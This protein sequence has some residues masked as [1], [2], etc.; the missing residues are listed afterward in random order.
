MLSSFDNTSM[1]NSDPMGYFQVYMH[2]LIVLCTPRD[3]GLKKSFGLAWN[4]FHIFMNYGI[5][6]ERVFAEK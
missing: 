6:D 2:V 1:V 4:L 3:N 5:Y